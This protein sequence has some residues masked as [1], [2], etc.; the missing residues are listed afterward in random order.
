MRSLPLK[1]ATA[2]AL[3]MVLPTKQ[4][5]G[6]SK[7]FIVKE[8][9][10]SETARANLPERRILSS[11]HDALT[12][13]YT[14]DSYDLHEIEVPER[15]E[16]FQ[17]LRINSLSMSSK[18]GA[19]ALPVLIERIV[20][21]ENTR[22]VIRMG[23]SEYT[24]V[25]GLKIYPAQP[26]PGDGEHSLIDF[27]LDQEAYQQDAFSPH[28]LVDIVDIQKFKGKTIAF[29]Q[30]RPVQYNPVTGTAR[31]YKHLDFS[32]EYRNKF[33]NGKA[34]RMH[35]QRIIENTS[36]DK[37]Q[38][39][40]AG[41]GK[42]GTSATPVGY[43]ILT[44]PQFET[45]AKKLARWKEQMGYEV[46]ILTTGSWTTASAKSAIDD[47]YNTASHTPEYLLIF[48]DQEHIPDYLY[49]DD[50]NGNPWYVY[51]TNYYACM[52]GSSDYMPE[53]SH[54]RIAVQNA[55][56]AMVVVNKIISYEQNPPA[57]PDFY[58]KGIH[59]GYFQDSLRDGTSDYRYARTTIEMYDYMT[60]LGFD[61]DLILYTES[62]VYPNKFNPYFSGV[63]D[64]PDQYKKS[65]GYAWDG[66]KDD[67]IS[68]INEGRLY[69]FHRDH[70]L[71]DQ[72][73]APYFHISHMNQLTNID[74]LT[75]FFSVNC[76]T[77][78]FI[79]AEPAMISFAETL[80]RNPNGG[81]AGV[82]AA[83]SQTKSGFNDALII[84]MMDAIW[85]DPGINPDFG[86]A[87]NSG[88]PAAHDPIYNMGDVMIQGL[89]RM[90][91]TWDENGWANKNQFHLYH[92]FG[93][94]AMRIWSRQ[95]TVISANHAPG[96]QPGDT[97]FEV[98]GSNC[99]GGLATL[100][101]GGELVA[102]V[103]LGNGAGTLE[104][105][106]PVTA[107][108]TDIVLTI[109]SA[110]YKPYITD[111]AVNS[112]DF[113]NILPLGNSLTYDQRIVDDRD[114]SEKIAYRKDLFELLNE[115]EIDFNF[116]GSETSGGGL[117]SDPENGG[118][119]GM[120]APQLL[121]LLQTGYNQVSG[122]QET[123]TFYLDEYNPDI[124]LLHIGT[125][126]LTTDIS[127]LESILDEIDA[128]KT[129][130]GSTTKTILAC[131]MNQVPVNADV[132]T[133]NTNM[134]NLIS[135]RADTC[136]YLI[137]MENA[138]G[139]NYALQPDGD[140]YDQYHPNPKGFTKMAQ[141]WMDGITE[142]TY[143]KPDV[144]LILNVSDA[145]ILLGEDYY[146]DM[147]ALST[148]PATLGVSGLVNGM[149]FDAKL[150]I[151]QW[152]PD[153]T[154]T[155]NLSFTA[156]NSQGSATEEISLTVSEE[157][158]TPATPSNLSTTLNGTTI[159]I[160][161]NDESDD[162]TAFEMERS[163]NGS[164][165]TL[166]ATPGANTESATDVI[167]QFDITYYYRV[168]AINAYGGS[169]YISSGALYVS[170]EPEEKN[171]GYETILSSPV[172]VSNRRAQKVTM[173]EDGTLTSITM[174]HGAT[175]GNLLF[176][177]YA[178][179][180]G[181]PGARLGVTPVTSSASSEGWQEVDL[182]ESVFVEAN[183]SIWLSW[184]YEHAPSI[185]YTSGGE[186]RASS[187]DTYSAGMPADFGYS[188][189]AA[190]MYSIYVTY[191]TAASNPVPATPT[192]L[193]LSYTE[194]TPSVILNW[195][196]NASDE[197]DILVERSDN[198]ADYIVVAI[199]VANSTSWTDNTLAYNNDYSYRVYAGNA[200]GYSDYSNI[201]SI[202]TDYT[203]PGAPNTPKNLSADYNQDVPLI[204]LAWDDLSIDEDNFILERKINSG[205]YSAL[206]SL[207]ANVTTYTD[208]DITY[209]NSYTY[210]LFAQNSTGNSDT[211][212][213]EAISAT[214][215]AAPAAPTNIAISLGGTAIS[216]SWTDESDDE[217]GFELERS[218]D[219]A[220]FSLIATLAEN[221]EEATDV[222]STYNTNYYYRVRAINAYGESDYLTSG[223]LYVS[224]VSDE[225]KV[226]Y[227]DE[228]S[229]PVYVT[230]R[231]AQKVTM[232]EDG[233]I[234][235]VTMYHGATYG[236]LIY[237]VYADNNGVPGT[238]LAVTPVTAVSGSA[239]W[240]E[241]DLAESVFIKA[242][243]S[244]WLSWVY[245]HAP[246]IL[247]TT[248]GEGRA[249]SSA[250]YSGG[251]PSDFGS[252]SVAAYRYSIYAT[253]QTSVVNP[254]PAAPSN[255]EAAY[256]ENET[257]LIL[258]WD[259]NASDE[260]SY[261]V[262]RSDNGGSFVI[263]ASL[264]ANST[265]WTD[266][267]IALNNDY[268]YR[269][270]ISNANGNSGYSNAVLVNTDY[271][272]PAVPEAP[273]D[274]IAVYNQDIPSVTLSWSDTSDD[275]D[276]FTIER[277]ENSGAWAV[278]ASLAANSTSWTDNSINY[279]N[280]YDYRAAAYNNIGSS[281]YAAG[282][283]IFAEQFMPP[284]DPSDISL[285]YDAEVPEIVISWTD[286]SDN[287]E[288]FTLE[289][290]IN[291]GAFS[292]L[293]ALAV[294]TVSY[295]D[296]AISYGDDYG[297]RISAYNEKGSSAAATSMTISAD[298]PA[299]APL[300]PTSL[301]AIYDQDIPSV[302]LSWTDHAE[303]ED[304]F[305]VESSTDAGGYVSLANTGAD[306]TTFED[307]S[308][309]YNHD[310][311]FRVLAYNS[312]GESDYS[313]TVSITSTEP[314]ND[315]IQVGHTDVYSTPV[316]TA[317]RR[318]QQIIV[319]ESGVI[320]SI[321]M[322]MNPYTPGY[323]IL[324]IY[325]NHEGHPDQLLATTPSAMQ[326]SG[327]S[328]NTAA[329]TSPLSVTAGQAIWLAWTFQHGTTIYYT[330]GTPGRADSQQYWTG[331]LPASF[332]SS[333]VTSYVYSIYMTMYPD[334]TKEANELTAGIDTKS[335]L[336]VYP[337]P[338]RGNSL[339]YMLTDMKEDGMYNVELVDL[340][341]RILYREESWIEAGKD[342]ELLFEKPFDISL[343]IFRVYNQDEMHLHKVSV[344]N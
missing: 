102:E 64:V 84:G 16:N 304:G 63:T 155:F 196:D 42:A 291:G 333:S 278:V 134:A 89:V 6:Q 142:A 197:M 272:A 153:Q 319:S 159:T 312:F 204:N 329:L 101:I 322:Y 299:V 175:Y 318:A 25:K 124:I 128:F 191:Q 229:S 320:E 40:L 133:F 280:S 21:P 274:L 249:S 298:I 309:E 192:N 28:R 337:N 216:I 126:G 92:Y 328:W 103:K 245:E 9:Q 338:L 72:W 201:V 300:A 225:K 56:Q 15:Q 181:V 190:Y 85:A 222:I 236:N 214:E 266:N 156:T 315:P 139:V 132:T 198:G 100:C 123:G 23:S 206:A 113:L 91:E 250:T 256:T 276:G 220:T 185:R 20:I 200:N 19:P 34:S 228:F 3:V 243:T 237:G 162:E 264:C 2:I 104:L 295:T 207:D 257:R 29:I 147:M 273:T 52:D 336:F 286:N 61:S 287:E 223:A 182:T 230:N 174:Y 184:V 293:T 130:T 221:S 188:S 260:E 43:L 157:I 79:Y 224:S 76:G 199:L 218:T 8:N 332:G 242:N 340:S 136:L 301:T 164:D 324:G 116:V 95:P 195:T 255:L 77:G 271:V 265:S 261:T 326:N 129:R 173:P 263:V 252:G 178:D 215:P 321:S 292:S 152:T 163:N 232:P 96:L 109:T 35:D 27:T 177:V 331:S 121:H 212:G 107:D 176:A 13:E 240:Q 168:R 226:G 166:I 306:E 193:G 239:G 284:A 54:G 154:G 45:A 60:S 305:T 120:T 279:N 165:F 327:A 146:L 41:F 38:P 262:E 67:I 106:N 339:H 44:V 66:N 342:N 334:A 68:S 75:I 26:V 183:T 172:Y 247:Y 80:L 105:P 269:V 160:S 169:D 277:S 317:Y 1:L 108:M 17:L 254:V 82:V 90:T 150:G 267:T 78:Q 323:F 158:L 285:S 127:T 98:T 235:S 50:I 227:E 161:W 110:N 248:G 296:A 135:G 88:T 69:A 343:L 313:N 234:Q 302:Q 205:A 268:S 213:T 24:D 114:A 112:G 125:N 341:G 258:T 297:Y 209:G 47:Y 308:I 253:Y 32:I 344:E 140:M 187:G 141:V 171:L 167:S 4:T 86:M 143:R 57:D 138:S 270:M 33:I 5:N 65:N 189:V 73:M 325:S 335:S 290:S 58:N 238:R 111:L 330:S 55:E 115:A 30:V 10:V 303:F 148:E 283:S 233:T 14:F 246:Q 12:L 51:S 210:R 62:S 94:P 194:S 36:I 310:Y 18:A 131:I 151:L 71:I 202:N 186:G 241:V 53:M 282:I 294:N 145:A 179:E 119:P 83:T 219:G 49:V 251:M 117:F 289:R 74:K 275:E 137:D 99:P 118:F 217:T 39:S 11:S 203:E 7:S 48:G 314:N 170:S 231:R 281:P 87:D 81:A 70:G 316:F 259:D 288:G 208:A 122:T 244:I 144:P 22:P 31:F 311:T 180:G 97:R 37:V 149:N 59:A 93:D 211:L 307:L 46:E